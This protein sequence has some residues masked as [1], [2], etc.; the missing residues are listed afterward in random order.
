MSS[1]S[2]ARISASSSR[3]ARNTKRDVAASRSKVIGASSISNSSRIVAGTGSSGS[4]RSAR[5]FLDGADVTPQSLLVSRIKPSTAAQ[6][7]GGKVRGKGA[8]RSKGSNAPVAGQS[9]MGASVIFSSASVA[10]E[11]DSDGESSATLIT[12]AKSQTKPSQPKP[13]VTSAPQPA[14]NQD[15]DEGT[16]DGDATPSDVGKG[17]G[18]DDE[19]GGSGATSA[20]TGAGVQGA[21]GAA[22][23]LD[24][25]RRRPLTVLLEETPTI[26][27]FELRSVCV[28]LDAPN[29][30]AVVA[31][32]KRY[33]ELC[34]GKKGSD[35]YVEGRS[36]TLQLAQKAKEVMTA[37]PATRDAAVTATDWDIFDWCVAP[38]LCPLAAS[39]LTA[40]LAARD[41]RKRAATSRR[42]KAATAQAVQMRRRQHLRHISSAK[43]DSTRRP[44]AQW[45]RE[46]SSVTRSC[47]AR[48]TRSSAP[49]WHRPGV[50]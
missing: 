11:T 23:A 45:G 9:V 44:R 33:V 15:D 46:A 34:A 32:N 6:Q 10:S 24:R 27:L 29:H 40:F 35:R 37:P 36:Q 17:A 2:S 28:A 19:T 47:S 38:S 43:G 20:M 13:S 48:W 31:R 30:Q 39:R 18:F 26:M 7:R 50:C 21:D 42:T 5:V 41:S 25:G 4:G 16:Q 22:M 49:R 1:P 14:S 3:I 12:T 8:G